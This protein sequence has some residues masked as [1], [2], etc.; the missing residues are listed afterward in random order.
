MYYSFTVFLLTVP[1]EKILL[2]HSPHIPLTALRG[3]DETTIKMAG[4]LERCGLTHTEEDQSQPSQI[5]S[6]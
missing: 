2:Q 3:K 6:R 1:V 4:H 5:Y